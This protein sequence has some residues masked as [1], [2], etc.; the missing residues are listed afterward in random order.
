MKLT[1]L[2]SGTIVPELERHMAGNLL[3]AGGKRMLFDAGP[4]TVYQILKAKVDIRDI[5]H[6]FFTHYHNDH[7]SDL[8]ALLWIYHGR[9]KRERTLNLYGPAGFEGYVDLLSKKIMKQDKLD[10]PF[11]PKGNDETEFTADGIKISTRRM[12]H[13]EAVGYRV[14]HNGKVFAYTGDTGFFPGLIG[15]A[16]GADVL[17]CECALM[18]ENL[19]DEKH[20]TPEECGKVAKEAGVKRLV[21][22]HMYP[23]TPRE[24]AKEI[25]QGIFGG[26]VVVARDLMEIEF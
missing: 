14:E 7:I 3:D 1:V 21:L 8:P 6:M 5:D 10:C 4:G 12:N 19:G 24:K 25:I 15:F 9:L 26:E 20:M 17:L 2:G 13:T 11:V 22:T 23:E 18:E 16:R